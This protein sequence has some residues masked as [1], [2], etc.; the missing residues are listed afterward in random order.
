ML[1]SCASKLKSLEIYSFFRSI[2]LPLKQTPQYLIH[3]KDI[4]HLSQHVTESILSIIL[5][6]NLLDNDFRK[7]DDSFPGVPKTENTSGVNVPPSTS[8]IL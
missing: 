8:I 7:F 1:A 4:L 5:V 3:M 6:L 2:L